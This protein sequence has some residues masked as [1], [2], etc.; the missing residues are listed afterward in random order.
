MFDDFTLTVIDLPDATLRVRHGG[1]GPAVLLLHGHPR[2]HTTWWRVAPLLA[3]THTVV[4]PDLRGFG[5]SSKPADR[6]EHA[7]SSKLAKAA[8]CVELMRELG[9]EALCGRR[10]DQGAYVAFRAALDHPDAIHTSGGAS[11]PCRSWMHSSAAMP[12]LHKPGGIGSSLPSP[13]SPS[14]RSWPTQVPGME[15]RCRRWASRTHEDDWQAI[16]DPE[17]VPRG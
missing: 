11:P 7:G 4:C 5:R 2:T 1:S 6:P 9:H 3:A 10:A 17:T 15:V 8:D 16:H 13:R 14:A 12:A